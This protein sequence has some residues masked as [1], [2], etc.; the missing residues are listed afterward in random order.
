MDIQIQKIINYPDGRP[1]FYFV[2]LEYVENIEQILE[3]EEEE[4]QE[5]QIDEVILDGDRIK[6]RYPLL[7][8]GKIE[9]LW[10]G[11]ERSVARTYEA[12]PFVIELTFPEPREMNGVSLVVGDTDVRIDA[13]LYPA[14][15]VQ[16]EQIT[17]ELSG[18]VQE[19]KVYFEFGEPKHVKVL[20][21]EVRDLLQGEPAHVHLWEI[22]FD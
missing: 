14:E 7:D 17:S 16:P 9:D 11:D 1:G 8:M 18:S 6:V 19:P 10:D 4:R 13:N 20:V 2:R 22:Q 15:G 3:K 21:L 12:N 5:L